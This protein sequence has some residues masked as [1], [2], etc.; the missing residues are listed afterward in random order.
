[1]RFVV[2][3]EDS[4]DMV[5]VRLRLEPEHLAF[6]NAHRD[7][8]PMAGGLRH[9]HG[10]AYV[11]GLWVFEVDGKQRAVELIE[12]DPYFIACPRA[13]RLLAWGKALPQ[14]LVTL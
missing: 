6:L 9:E 7:E 1:M 12:Q 3:F 10:G 13:Y 2:I 11:G 4:P 8:I 5:A 14:Y